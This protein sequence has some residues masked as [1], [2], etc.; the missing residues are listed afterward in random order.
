MFLFFLLSLS[1]LSITEQKDVEKKRGKKKTRKEWESDL[2]THPATRMKEVR[3]VGREAGESR[4]G[5]RCDWASEGCWQITFTNNTSSKCLRETRC[6]SLG[7]WKVERCTVTW[8]LQLP[9]GNYTH[10]RFLW[11]YPRDPRKHTPRFGLLPPHHAVKFLQR[12]LA[13]CGEEFGEGVRAHVEGLVQV[14]LPNELG[15]ALTHILHSLALF[16]FLEF[17]I[18]SCCCFC[19]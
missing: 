2:S 16:V 1:L 17:P 15:A 14:G 10:N 18:M 11:R 7:G 6:D 9:P 19:A 12:A 4:R 3:R 5:S 8:G 13:V